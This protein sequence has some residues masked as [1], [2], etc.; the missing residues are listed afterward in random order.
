MTPPFDAHQF[1]IRFD[2]TPAL[3]DVRMAAAGDRAFCRRLYLAS[4]E[5]LLST[6]HAWDPKRVDETFDEF[7][8]ADEIRIVRLDG[9]DIGYL[10]VTLSDGAM[11]LDQI[12]LREAFRRH[13]IGTRL[14]HQV[15][16]AAH[17]IGVPLKLILIRGNRAEALYTRLG[18]TMIDECATKRYMAL[19]PNVRSN[20]RRPQ[21]L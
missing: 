12:H 3:V 21:S 9:E 1:C 8:V 18:F 15:I 2:A 10:Q 19:E 6:L 17:I 7:F 11:H 5:P 13:G 20:S 16:D 4:M 14:I